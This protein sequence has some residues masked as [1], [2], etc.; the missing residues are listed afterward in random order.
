MEKACLLG[1]GPFSASS[2][3]AEGRLTGVTVGEL[4]TLVLC[5]ITA[6]VFVAAQKYSAAA[7]ITHIR[8]MRVLFTHRIFF[9]DKVW[10]EYL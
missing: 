9:M 5:L 1:R 2:A 7:S 4:L 10:A 3:S 8:N 6:R